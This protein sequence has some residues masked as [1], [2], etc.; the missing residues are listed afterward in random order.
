MNYW[1]K[2]KKGGILAGHDINMVGVLNA[3]QDFCKK[4]NL[5]FQVA[6]QDWW[7]VKNNN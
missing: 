6:G 2:V 7:I 3:V 1:P 4:K 5:N